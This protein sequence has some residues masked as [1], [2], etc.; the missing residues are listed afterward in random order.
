[1]NP[2]SNI[3]Q[4]I[5]DLFKS[6]LKNKPLSINE[7][8]NM[9]GTDETRLKSFNAVEMASLEREKISTNE[10]ISKTTDDFFYYPVDNLN[11]NFSS[12]KKGNIINLCMYSITLGDY[13]P[14]IQYLLYKHNKSNILTF[15]FFEF[16]KGNLLDLC[17]KKLK[18]ILD[19]DF[20][21]KGYVKEKNNVYLIITLPNDFCV[22]QHLT[23]DKEWWFTLLSE[24]INEE[25]ILYFPIH[26]SVLNLFYKN[27]DLLYLLDE[28][29]MPYESPLAL[30]NG[31]HADKTNFIAK[32]GISKFSPLA[33]MGPYYYFSTY[34]L[35][36]KFGSYSYN[37]KPFKIDDQIITDNDFGRYVKGGIVRFAIFTGRLKVFLNRDWDK[38]DESLLSK[39]REERERKIIQMDGSWTKN[40]DSTCVAEI[41][42]SDKSINQ[43]GTKY[44]VKNYYQQTP[45]SYHFLDKSTVPEMF[46]PDK[47]IKII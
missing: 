14:F 26:T 43:N 4:Q 18:S 29:N 2:S 9:A 45:L 6:S 46:K 19:V 13:K 44:C 39:N 40:Y 3:K 22:L 47:L 12:I 5:S 8:I 37:F 28:D 32:F 1:M 33:S 38:R 41:V 23:S 31:Q 36:C 30:Y 16:D 21:I 20:L 17:N 11:R 24:I 25:K 42:Y 15:P 10:I 7:N 35:A 27:P 34:N